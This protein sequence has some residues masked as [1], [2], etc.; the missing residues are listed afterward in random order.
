LQHAALLNPEFLV[1]G[2]E[3]L[4]DA[5]KAT[6]VGRGDEEGAVVG[7]QPVTG[8]VEDG[9][10]GLTGFDAPNQLGA[11]VGRCGGAISEGL[12]QGEAGAE[13]LA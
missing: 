4:Q 7:G 5:R 9:G 13:L 11:V 10:E 3:V 1:A 12:R 8:G 6:G 2:G